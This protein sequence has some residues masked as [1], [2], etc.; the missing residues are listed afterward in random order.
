MNGGGQTRDEARKKSGAAF[1]A[2]RVGTA[3]PA[4][5]CRFRQALERL[6]I[7]PGSSTTSNPQNIS[8]EQLKVVLIFHAR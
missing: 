6:E 2:R 5:L 3:A 1:L 8:F 4:A 7:A